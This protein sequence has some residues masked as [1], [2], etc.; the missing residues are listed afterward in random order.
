LSLLLTLQ[1]AVV[2]GANLSGELNNGD[3][4]ANGCRKT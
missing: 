2:V 1:L 4:D 3:E